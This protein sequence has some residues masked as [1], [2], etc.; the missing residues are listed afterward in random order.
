M[1][2]KTEKLVLT[3]R[4]ALVAAAGAAIAGGLP[5]R[6]RGAEKFPARPVVIYVGSKA[7]SPVDVY[8]RT[9]GKLA[10]PHLGQSIQV[11]NREGGSSTI[12]MA[13]MLNQ[14]A[15]GYSL[16]GGTRSMTTVLVEMDTGFGLDDFQFVIRSQVDP[17]MFA[18]PG[19][20][21]YETLAQFVDA[22]KQAPGKMKVGGFGTGTPHHIAMQ[23]FA[24]V[25]GVQYGWIPYDG[26]SAATAAVM[27]GHIDAVMTN[28]GQ[29]RGKGD[30]IRPLAVTATERLKA[31]PNLKTFTELGYRVTDLHW[32]GLVTKKGVPE[33]RVEVLHQAFK[34]AMDS[35]EWR[36]FTEKQ[37]QE[38][39]YMGPAEFTREAKT[40]HE[41]AHEVLKELGLAKKTAAR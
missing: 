34:K 26:G 4:Q 27:G 25:A 1:S 10:E 32:R 41:E 40:N 18:V 33:D 14:P 24:K 39:G 9:I 7:G 6:A 23:R 21:R 30:R 20:S 31:F 5:G 3:R 11:Q 2:S 36:D 16:Y 17:F 8:A 13:T 12:A 37:G 15:D 28:P 35:D 38:S 29:A 22:A 19:S